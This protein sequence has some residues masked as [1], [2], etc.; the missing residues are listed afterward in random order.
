M[1]QLGTCFKLNVVWQLTEFFRMIYCREMIC[2][3]A[4]PFAATAAEFYSL[5]VGEKTRL[6]CVVVVI[7]PLI[8]L[9]IDT[10]A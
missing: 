3:F 6:H 4:V 8:K 10:Y 1:H 5:I 2:M 7:S 9:G